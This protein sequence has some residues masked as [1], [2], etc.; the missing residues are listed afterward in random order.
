MGSVLVVDD[1]SSIR[2]V[3]AAWAE[4]LGHEVREAANAADALARMAERPAGVVVSDVNMP[5]HDGIWLAR[6]LREEY[7]DTAVIM[8]TGNQDAETALSSLRLGVV[9]FL[10]KPFSGEQFRQALARG[11]RW[12]SE[13][14]QARQRLH[15]LQREV[16]E[17]LGQIEAFVAEV[18]VVSDA[19]LDRLIEGIMP[20]QSAIEHARRVAALATNMAVHMGIR[21][22]ELAE[23][24]RA[25]LL[26]D[27]G[28]VAMPAAIL[29]KPAR[30]SDEEIAIVREQPRFVSDILD[31]NAFLAPTAVMVRAIFEHV[32]GT[33]YP[34][35]LRGDEI[36]RG[37]RIIAV[38]DA[39]D[40]MTHHRF[41]RELR[42]PSE[43]IFEIQR[44]AGTHF[45]PSAVEAL[46]SVIHL[47]WAFVARQ[48]A[49]EPEAS[50]AQDTAAPSGPVD[51]PWNQPAPY[52]TNPS[53]DPSPAARPA[54]GPAGPAHRGEPVTPRFPRARRPDNS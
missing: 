10:S 43:A 54:D 23:I 5:D 32:D 36:P 24:E 27:L 52:V 22:P 45:D 44:C 7:P 13:A 14:E 46:L 35:A 25:A 21:S 18:P 20:D 42:T 53:R 11:V 38:A 6:R 8:A 47:H 49:P 9:D 37:A 16:R 30:L 26:H 34:F 29:C 15:V 33:G 40:A 41:Y 1:E 17:H 39:L 19:D 28:R 3:T 51:A 31:R 2:E 48:P 4:R 50:D 12:H